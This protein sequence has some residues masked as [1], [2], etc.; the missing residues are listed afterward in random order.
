[1]AI[2]QIADAAALPPELSRILALVKNLDERVEGTFHRVS[3]GLL[4]GTQLCIMC[5][6]AVLPQDHSS[7]SG[8]LRL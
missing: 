8:G 2:F 3:N 4:S 7:M 1:M 6:F 5:E